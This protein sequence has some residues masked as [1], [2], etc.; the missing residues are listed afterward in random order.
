M[1][2]V[3]ILLGSFVFVA[4]LTY[5]ILSLFYRHQGRG[6]PKMQFDTFLALYESAPSKWDISSTFRCLYYYK[7]EDTGY[8]R[9]IIYMRSLFDYIALRLWMWFDDKEKDAE[10]EKH[11]TLELIELWKHDLSGHDIP[12]YRG[13]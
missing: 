7:D 5:V 8:S 4:S 1:K 2:T 10:K 11:K 9:E 12:D 13:G 6:Y 3:L